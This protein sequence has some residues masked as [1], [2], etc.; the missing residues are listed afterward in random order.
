[1]VARVKKEKT[2]KELM[3]EKMKLEIAE[4]LGLI[5]KIEQ[6]GWAGLNAI[7]T[8]RIGGI[9]NRRLKSNER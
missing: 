8:G 9:M 3:L 5:E 6:V 4:E 1:M 2:A 7:E